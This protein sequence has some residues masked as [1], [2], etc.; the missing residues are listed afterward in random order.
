MNIIRFFFKTLLFSW[1]LVSLPSPP[2]RRICTSLARRSVARSSHTWYVTILIF[3]VC[4]AFLFTGSRGPG[5]SGLLRAGFGRSV[6]ETARGE[7]VWSV[8]NERS[9][10][11]SPVLLSGEILDFLLLETPFFLP[12]QVNFDDVYNK[13]LSPPCIPNPRRRKRGDT[14]EFK[15][16][17][18][19]TKNENDILFRDF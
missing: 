6:A 10:Q 17:L 1:D 9:R 18:C 2:S 13:T 3:Y 12:P 15:P 5:G 19:Q 8:G 14:E 11:E 16:N 7:G 4:L